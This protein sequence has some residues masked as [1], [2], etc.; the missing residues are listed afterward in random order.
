MY[1]FYNYLNEFCFKMLVMYIMLLI[2]ISN[3]VVVTEFTDLD[4]MPGK[5]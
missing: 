1:C 4:P 5:K 2:K 3:N